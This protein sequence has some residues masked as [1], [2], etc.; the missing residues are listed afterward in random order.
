MNACLL[1]LSILATCLGA[2]EVPE[3]PLPPHPRLLFN[4]EGIA[5]L[6]TR[7]EQ[8]DWAREAWEGILAELAGT[9]DAP[10]EIPPRGGNWPHWYVCPEHGARMNRGKEVGPWQWEHICPIDNKV[11]LSST[12]Q[13]SQDYDGV[14]LH[15]IHQ[16]WAYRL[17]ELGVAYQVTGD[18]RYAAKGAEIIRAYTTLYP[19][20][21]LHNVR[22]EAK[23]GGARILSQ[24]L[25][26]AVWL[27]PFCQGADL[28]WETLEESLRQEMAEKL[29]L[30]MVHEVILPH[31]LGVHNIQCWKNSAVALAGLL[32]DERD[33]VKQ[34]IQDPERGYL[35]QLEK[36]VGPDGQWWEGAWSYHFYTM[37][38]VWPLPEAARNCGFD[39]YV[40]PVKRMYDAPLRFAMPNLHLPAFNDSGEVSLEGVASEYELGYARFGNPDYLRLLKKA[41]RKRATALYFG[42]D[43]LP[44][45]PSHSWSG[46]N[47]PATGVAILADGEGTAA[48]WFCLK[49]GPHGGG[50]GHPDKLSFVLYTAGGVLAQDPGTAAYGAPIQKDWF[51]TTFAHNTLVIDETCQ[52]AAEG[53][54]LAF[55]SEAG[56]QYVMAEVKDIYKG[57]RLVRTAVLL[58]GGALCFIDQV[59]CDAEHQLDMVYHQAGSWQDLPGGDPWTPPEAQGYMHVRDGSVRP[60]GQGMTLTTDANGGTP[61]VILPDPAYETDIITGT[62]VGT[63]VEDR[64][65]LV[66]M[67]RKAAATTFR[68]AVSLGGK[69]LDMESLPAEDG[70]ARMRIALEDGPSWSI[71]ANA[72]AGNVTISRLGKPSE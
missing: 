42:V 61:I 63:H 56:A 51:R 10:V 43:A 67:R 26:E 39:L 58:P 4:A 55:G 47:Y 48:T 53:K 40:D 62:G 18:A 23:V 33:L 6:K 65:P 44:E 70:A 52:R 9:L 46:V 31:K 32:L 60:L 68:W 12:A 11:Y 64:V 34:A 28:V 24:T 69:A 54:C 16:S 14:I 49:Y 30:P 17:R 1:S 38:A 29:I 35:V 19:S 57:A 50:H 8:H 45:A 59:A 21:P 20:L 71:A 72:D 7:I 3:G 25:D 37:S 66:I 27:I 41:D 36:G 5:Q 2:G 22:G 15:G 13:S